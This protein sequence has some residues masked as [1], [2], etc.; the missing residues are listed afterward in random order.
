[1]NGKNKKLPSI[2]VL[3]NRSSEYMK[4]SYRVNSLH[5]GGPYHVE[6]SPMICR[7]NQWTGFYVIG[8]SVVKGLMSN[9]P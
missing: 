5:D 1:M 2:G 9:P 7:A 4:I 8:T 6:T 3:E